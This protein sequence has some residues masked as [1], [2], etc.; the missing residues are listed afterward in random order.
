[1]T[2]LYALQTALVVNGTPVYSFTTT[3]VLMKVDWPCTETLTLYFMKILYSFLP[4]VLVSEVELYLSC[5]LST[6]AETWTHY[7]GKRYKLLYCV[8][9]TVYLIIICL[10][11][12][13][14]CCYSDVYHNKSIL[15]IHSV[16]PLPII[17]FMSLYTPSTRAHLD[18]HTEEHSSPYQGELHHGVSVHVHLYGV[19]QSLC[20]SVDLSVCLSVHVCLSVCLCVM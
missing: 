17:V 7:K 8:L 9:I 13:I 3:L 16:V 10:L 2:G 20:L 12:A 5:Y 11:I 18:H 15:F 6:G 19:Y 1:M 4:I 14:W